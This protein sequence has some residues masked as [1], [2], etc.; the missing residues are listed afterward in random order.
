MEG[1][2]EVLA[3]LPV[4]FGCIVPTFI[5]ALPLVCCMIEVPRIWLFAVRNIVSQFL[6]HGVRV[7][8]TGETA[9]V[10]ACIGNLKVTCFEE[11]FYSDVCVYNLSKASAFYSMGDF[12]LALCSLRQFNSRVPRYMSFTE[13]TLSSPLPVGIV[14]LAMAFEFGEAKQYVGHGC[15]IGTRFCCNS[16]CAG[17]VPS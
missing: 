5:S 17:Y 6:L 7:A 8:V 1:R 13:S 4:S 11:F 16:V 10:R 14:C 3:V 2:L 9:P 12:A 15:H